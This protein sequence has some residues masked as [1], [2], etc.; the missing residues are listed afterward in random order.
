MTYARLQQDESKGESDKLDSEHQYQQAP[1]WGVLELGKSLAG[2]AAGLLS[3]VGLGG[4]V[5][6]NQATN[7]STATDARQKHGNDGLDDK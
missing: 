3:S 4:G 1:G 7:G 6:E 2:S 5:G